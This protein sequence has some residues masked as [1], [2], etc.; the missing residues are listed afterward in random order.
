MSRSD[1]L[2]GVRPYARPS[3]GVFTTSR[4]LEQLLSTYWRICGR[5]VGLGGELQ[6]LSTCMP[7]STRPPRAVAGFAML[8]IGPQPEQVPN[9]LISAL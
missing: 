5:F 2:S 4:L 9:W 1:P 6:W 7:T 8:S 3:V